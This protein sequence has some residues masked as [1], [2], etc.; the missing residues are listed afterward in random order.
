[1]VRFDFVL[2]ADL[3]V[4]LM[5]ANMSPN[6]S[7]KHFR[8]NRQLYEN[9]LY[10]ILSLVGVGRRIKSSSLS[11]IW[12]AEEEMEV[13]EKNLMV[14]GDECSNDA[15][16]ECGGL[17][18]ALCRHCLTDHSVRI[19]KESYLEHVNRVDCKRIFPPSFVS[20][21]EEKNITFEDNLW[22]IN[23]CIFFPPNI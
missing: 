19:L 12:V 10:S 3:N 4:Y 13:P 11:H 20:R 17:E 21:K 15:C 2:D 16:N 8:Q 18:C 6:L 7:S 5:E 9:V 23:G 14:Y 1:M 22:F